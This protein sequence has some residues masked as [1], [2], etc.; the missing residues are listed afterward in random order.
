MD[1]TPLNLLLQAKSKDFVLKVC[2]Q[3]VNKEHHSEVLEVVSSTL[4][5]SVTQS[6]ELL[7]TMHS[8][9][10]TCIERGVTEASDIVKLF[11][12]D[13]HRS[14]CSLIT[15]IFVEH[16]PAWSRRAAEEQVGHPRLET[17]SWSI[18]VKQDAAPLC[19]L[20]LNIKDREG[21]K[22]V[23]VNLSKES[24]SSLLSGLKQV[25]EQINSMSNEG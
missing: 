13:F 23:N 4:E 21:A 16:L 8:L 12:E 19:F 10:N 17:F 2:L 11:P 6:E 1:L 5:C 7:H 18:N 15:K 25:K 3:A 9:I 24:L 20:N 22:S 14:L